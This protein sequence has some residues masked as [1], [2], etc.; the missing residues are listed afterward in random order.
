MVYKGLKNF[1]KHTFVP[2]EE[3]NY[4]PHFFREHVI[5]SMLIGIILLLLLSFT[6]YIIIRTTTFGS[7]VASSVLIDLTNQT[8]KKNGLSPLIYSKKLSDAAMMKGQDM[9]LR[10]YFAHFAPDGTSP[11][12]WF[13]KVG[14]KFLFAGENLA[15]NF[16]SSKEVEKAWMASPKHRDNILDTRYEEIG[17]ATVPGTVNNKL[18][19][20]VVQLFGKPVITDIPSSLTTKITPIDAH[21]Y[22]KLIFNATYYIN[23]IFVTFILILVLALMLMIFIEIQKQHYLHIFFGVLLIVTTVICIIINSLLL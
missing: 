4:K 19:L 11:W 10:E 15:I 1:L 17:I 16:R 22:E 21:F 5:L 18:V 6:S 2:H 12:H 13:S 23:T 3:N 8:R 14:Y 7:S 9:A 20:F